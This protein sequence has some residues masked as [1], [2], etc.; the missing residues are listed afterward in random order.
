MW[1][2]LAL[3]I[4]GIAWPWFSLK[5][6]TCELTFTEHR[7]FE[8]SET[9]AKLEITNRWP[10]P[11]YGLMV[12][13]NLLQEIVEHDDSIVTGLQRVPGWSVST[14][15]WNVVPKRRGLLPT[16]S[17]TLST[18]FPFGISSGTRVVTTSNQTIVWPECIG[19][20]GLP[21]LRNGKSNCQDSL[22]DIAGFEGDTIGVR[23]FR[24]GES[25]RYVHWAKSAQL[26]RLIV[27]ELQ[28][29]HRQSMHVVL[30]L[31]PESHSGKGNQGSFEWA[32]RAAATVCRQLHLNQVSVVVECIGLPD[33]DCSSAANDDGLEPLLDFF[34]MLPT[35]ASLSSSSSETKQ[36]KASV[37]PF[38]KHDQTI[39]ICTDASQLNKES[40][41]SVKAITILSDSFEHAVEGEIEVETDMLAGNHPSSTIVLTSPITASAQLASGWSSPSF[42]K[43]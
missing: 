31:S 32:I 11:I 19:L 36:L 28:R 43:A 29:N 15:S 13:A 37:S 5:G 17:P 9:I 7:T 27:K 14:F 30:D 34:S 24:Q 35:Y 3:L 33:H 22:V 12:E 42:V 8:N 4:V 41:T 26:D 25:M 20:E 1:A 23:D 40:H 21:L 10:I 39:L 16:E 2:L 6:L 38:E 18:G